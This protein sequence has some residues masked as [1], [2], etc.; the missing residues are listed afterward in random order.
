MVERSDVLKQFEYPL[1]LISCETGKISF[2]ASQSVSASFFIENRGGGELNGYLSSGAEALSFS[3]TSFSGNRVE[4]SFFFNI[5]SY[6]PGDSLESSLVI[7]SNGG[8][9]VIPIRI[10]VISPEIYAKDG[11]R[12]S[13]LMDYM[14]YAKANPVPSRQLFTQKEFLMWLLSMNYEHMELYDRFTMDS[15]KERAVDNFLIMNRL[16]RKAQAAVIEKNISLKLKY[17]EADPVTGVI[18]FRL[19]GWGYIDLKLRQK[20]ENTAVKLLT[21]KISYTDFDENGFF[22]ATFVVYPALVKS[23]RAYEQ[24]EITGDINAVCTISIIRERP[25][26]AEMLRSRFEAS[27]RGTILI[28]NNTGKDMMFSVVSSE[29]FIKFE[30]RRYLVGAKA[31]LPFEVRFT[32]LQSAQM[33]LRKQPFAEVVISLWSAEPVRFEKKFKI[34]VEL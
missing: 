5:E 1:P 18:M 10:D 3:P 32:A 25:V 8:E 30:G 34:T 6:R 31:E 12:I 22:E 14:F 9:L 24:I 17:R 11:Q 27:D 4:I 21:E 16:K 33:T 19:N 20:G 2:E 13:S 15:N 28:T 26:K 23:R 7:V 29:P